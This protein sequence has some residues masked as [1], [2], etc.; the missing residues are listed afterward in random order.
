MT[1]NFF[2]CLQWI[3]FISTHF[4]PFCYSLQR[5]IS[6]QSVKNTSDST[7]HFHLIYIGFFHGPPSPPLPPSPTTN[8]WV[9][10]NVSSQFRTFPSLFLYQLWYIKQPQSGRERGGFVQTV[11]APVC[12]AKLKSLDATVEEQEEERKNGWQKK[13][14][15]DAWW[16]K[17]CECA[18]NITWNK[19]RDQYITNNMDGT[20]I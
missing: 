5:H 16:C 12:N 15:K 18:V 1:A 2:K 11:L 7:Q 14:R 3:R 17:Y 19:E 9:E 8:R 4:I 10:S 6:R 13:W 20:A